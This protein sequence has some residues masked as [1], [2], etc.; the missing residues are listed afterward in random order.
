MWRASARTSASDGAGGQRKAGA[1][2]PRPNVLLFQG[3]LIFLRVEQPCPPFQ[4]RQR[5]LD[6]ATIV[7][8]HDDD[9]GYPLAHRFLG[10]ADPM[11]GDRCEAILLLRV[12]V[13]QAIDPFAAAVD[14][15]G[16]AHALGAGAPDGDSPLCLELGE[17]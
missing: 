10:S 3:S 16:E 15:A 4:A 5:R 14:R 8:V 12:D 17:T 2:S 7:G 6:L 13:D 1:S 11:A 9:A